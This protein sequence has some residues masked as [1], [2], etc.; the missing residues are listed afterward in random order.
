MF[1]KALVSFIPLA[2]VQ[3]QAL[4]T[5]SIIV[6]AS[7]VTT[8]Q[9]AKADDSF[10]DYLRSEQQQYTQD[11]NEAKQA[12]RKEKETFEAA[13]SAEEKAFT[14]ALAEEWQ[15]FQIQQ[16]IY[17]KPQNKPHSQPFH[18]IEPKNVGVISKISNTLFAEYTKPEKDAFYF[19]G[20]HI[21][22]NNQMIEHWPVLKSNDEDSIAAFWENLLQT[23]ID[24]ILQDI[25]DFQTKLELS[26]WATWQFV[27]Q[28]SISIYQDKN[29]Q[30]VLQ[31]FLMSKLGY[32]TRVARLDN[33]LVVL[34]ST[35]QQVYGS[36]YF[37]I[38][39]AR[40]Y[41][42][43]ADPLA[44]N[45]KIYSYGTALQLSTNEKSLDLNF[46]HSLITIP[47]IKTRK[48][49]YQYA[50]KD[51]QFDVPFDLQRIRYL[52]SHPQIDIDYYFDASMDNVTLQ[53]LRNELAQEITTG[54][55]KTQINQLLRFVQT[56]FRYAVDTEQF[57]KEN[58]LLP[59]E[60]FF[61][62]ASDCEDRSFLFARLVKDLFDKKIV[63]ALY[64]NH[65]ATAIDIS[66]TPSGSY[67]IADPTYAGAELGE[68]LP[69]YR[70][71][72]PKYIGM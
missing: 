23:E 27:K 8:V 51:H 50:G 3:N 13:V 4:T 10:A 49:A 66:D 37:Q 25:R 39:D 11:I 32:L 6:L 72:Q 22:L 44:G 52:S 58:Y 24:V 21:S 45:E 29:S 59:E 54:P 30:Q 41:L 1:I 5:V 7:S 28:Y 43:G 70:H 17:R 14:T 33:N 47:E 56:G 46:Q 61:Y 38:G 40:F 42:I 12:Q 67:T 9:K 64:P 48:I 36:P 31:W 34:L 18:G 65:V 62:E 63:G 55:L 69:E 15:A 2:F 60:L 68:V 35:Q 19:Y 71:I 16:G 26:D 53:F 20:H 57:G